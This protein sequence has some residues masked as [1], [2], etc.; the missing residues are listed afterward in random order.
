MSSKDQD[1]RATRDTKSRGLAI[2]QNE[3]VF[4]AM[5]ERASENFFA[6]RGFSARTIKTL[7]SNHIS[8]PEELLLMTDHEAV[9]V[10]GLDKAG[11]G[12]IQAYRKRF[13]SRANESGD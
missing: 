7:V 12:E 4:A 8:L 10:R 5:D 1:A 6:G 11:R 3:A 13:L 9:R 2:M